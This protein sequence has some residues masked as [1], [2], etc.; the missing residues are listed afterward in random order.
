[1]G[2]DIDVVDGGSVAPRRTA[3]DRLLGPHRGNERR[4]A[5]VDFVMRFVALAAAIIVIVPLVAI[6]GYVL[7]KGLPTLTIDF[8]THASGNTESPGAL[9]AI[10]GSL[11]MVPVALLVGGSLGLLAGIYLAEYAGPRMAAGGTFL[12][13]VLLGVPSILAGVLIY[14]TLVTY[15]TGSSAI[16]G[17]VALAVI[18][19]P[20]VIRATEEVLR[21]VPGSIRE[22]SLALGI[23]QWRTIV[24]VV[25]P[26]ARAGL[27][28]GIMLA[29]ARGFGETAPLL[30]TARGSEALNIGDWSSPMAALPLFVYQNSRLP[31]KTYVAQAWS[32]AIVLLAIVLAINVIVRGR[33]VGSRVE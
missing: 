15:V 14:A 26:V 2:V 20:I 25:A 31:D 32:A 4:R 9:N 27:L 7:V 23:A 24:S 11:Q 13:D 10:L 19:F 30:F 8:L 1:M 33:S 21:L 6:V 12:V 17:A 18:M 5:I 22:A 29:F 3:A 16:A 28:T